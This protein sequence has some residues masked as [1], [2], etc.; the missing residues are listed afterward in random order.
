[1]SRTFRKKNYEVENHT[2]WDTKG[3]KIAGFYTERTLHYEHGGF[4]YTYDIP[5]K[6]QYVDSYWK[7]HGESRSGNSVSPGKE[8]R[9]NRMKENRAIT[10]QELAKFFKN[11]EY[12]VMAETNPRSCWWD[13]D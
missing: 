4:W 6:Q 13:W 2:S 12:E 7:I 8:Y 3:K 5:T 11:T 1:M 9:R 10:R